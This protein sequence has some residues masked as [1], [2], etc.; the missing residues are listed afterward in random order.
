MRSAWASL[1]TRARRLS[2]AFLW[3]M[4]RRRGR[5]RHRPWRR[6]Q[7]DGAAKFIG[8]REV[9]LLLEP[10]YVNHSRPYP[11]QLAF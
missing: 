4:A 2:V 3:P 7:A 10:V 5:E 8:E 11:S 1:R 6:C 9:E